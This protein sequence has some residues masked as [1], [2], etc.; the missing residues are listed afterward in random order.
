MSTCESTVH[1]WT[2]NILSLFGMNELM[3]EHDINLLKRFSYNRIANL[4]TYQQHFV[5]TKIAMS[6]ISIQR[7]VYLFK[8][9]FVKCLN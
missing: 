5:R 3:N 9:L 7:K 8:Q 2:I 1:R 4:P 6:V